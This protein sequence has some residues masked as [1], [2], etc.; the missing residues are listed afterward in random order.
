[1][2][3]RTT[4]NFVVDI[5]AFGAFVLLAATGL[6]ERFV[7]PAGTGRFQSVWGMN[8]HEWGEIHLWIAWFL[9]LILAA[10]LL[11]HWKWI[12]CVIRGRE[13][14]AS[15]LRFGFGLV[16]LLGLAGL[17]LAPFLATVEQTGSPGWRSQQ[18]THD[19][20]SPKKLDSTS[21]ADIRGSMTLDDIERA[22][23]VATAVIIAGLGLPADVARDEK[24]G[25]LRRQYGFEMSDVR[26]IVEENTVPSG[27]SSA[28]VEKSPGVD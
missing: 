4:A 11:L 9:M 16:G 22:T 13:T 6:V 19:D 7:L 18:A 27:K 8:R 12:A 26:G 23:G 21:D 1:M 3:R 5:A 28:P 10:H 25:R 15:A 17:S 14:E 2:N 24:L 20:A